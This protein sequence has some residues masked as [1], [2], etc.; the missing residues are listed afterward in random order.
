[1]E[2]AS[3]MDLDKWVDFDRRKSRGQ[4]KDRK[5]LP[6][7][8]KVVAEVKSQE[9]RLET[10]WLRKGAGQCG[11]WWRREQERGLRLSTREPKRQVRVRLLN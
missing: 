11:M 8:A 4:R 6:G 7:K 10:V 2:L 9:S 5:H 1:M 3:Q